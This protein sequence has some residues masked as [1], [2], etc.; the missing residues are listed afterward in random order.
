VFLC[1]VL[2]CGASAAGGGLSAPGVFWVEAVRY[3]VFLFLNEIAGVRVGPS[4]HHRRENGH[5]AHFQCCARSAPFGHFAGLH[6]HHRRYVLA[7]FLLSQ[8]IC[9]PG[10]ECDVHDGGRGAVGC[11]AKSDQVNGSLFDISDGSRACGCVLDGEVLQI[12]ELFDCPLLVTRG[13]GCGVADEGS[14][15]SAQ[16]LE[17]VAVGVIVEGLGVDG[18]ED[19][20]DGW[21]RSGGFSVVHDG[22][23]SYV[24]ATG[25]ASCFPTSDLE[26]FVR[27]A[28]ADALLVAC[29]LG[30]RGDEGH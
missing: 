11:V 15:R 3:G 7:C 21:K 6:R 1:E 17:A 30:D 19:I 24:D 9:K 5:K 22:P 23:A 26:A 2:L 18:Y 20:G 28:F 29:S 14:D 10:A 25:G 12:E 8:D 4:V 27:C 16:C 13:G